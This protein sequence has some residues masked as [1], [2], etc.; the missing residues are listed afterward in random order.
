MEYRNKGNPA[1]LHLNR[2]NDL[3]STHITSNQFIPQFQQ[4]LSECFGQSSSYLFYPSFSES[5]M[6]FEN[7]SEYTCSSEILKQMPC[8]ASFS[9]VVYNNQKTW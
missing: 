2:L 4:H 8:F 3:L 5:L 6:E 9:H 7:A 1:K